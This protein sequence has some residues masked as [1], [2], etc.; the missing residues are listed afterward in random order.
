M[1]ADDH[2]ERFFRRRRATFPLAFM[3]FALAFCAL[4]LA[5]CA[6]WDG[7]PSSADAAKSDVASAKV[8]GLPSAKVPDEAS[9]IDVAFLEIPSSSFAAPKGVPW[10][11][12]DEAVIPVEVRARLEENGFRVGRIVAFDVSQMPKATEEG[13]NP[14]G[15]VGWTSDFDRRVRRLAC[16]DGQPYKLVLRRPSN[17]EVSTLI[18]SDG[19][20]SGRSLWNPQF[21]L[22]LRTTRMDDGR[23]AVKLVPEIHHG[24]VKRSYVSNDSLAFRMDSSRDVWVLNDLAIEVPLDEG[25]AVV[26]LPQ[27]NVF[28]LAKQMLIGKKVDDSEE[29]TAVVVHL[30]RRPQIALGGSR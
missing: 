23:V 28:G 30:S 6:V 4:V 19:G 9:I 3:W 24:E 29:R 13:E 8:P 18:R 22:A 12:L 15:A 11:V 1:L 16:S 21:N 27:D 25:Q 5:G 10:E 14:S 2:N 26:I 20:V 7:S 17:G